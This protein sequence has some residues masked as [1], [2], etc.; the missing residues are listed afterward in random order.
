[1]PDVSSK[2]VC[3]FGNHHWCALNGY[4]VEAND[5]IIVFCGKLQFSDTI[6]RTEKFKTEEYHLQPR[7]YLNVLPCPAKQETCS[8]VQSVEK[9][10]TADPPEKV[11][12]RSIKKP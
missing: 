2:V 9:Q 11:N 12:M 8:P 3:S 7:K 4:T 1:M 6:Q 5:I 10:Q